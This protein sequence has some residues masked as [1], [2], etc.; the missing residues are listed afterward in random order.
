MPG[1]IKKAL[2]LFK[3]KRR[4]KQNQPYPSTIIKYGAK[5]QYATPQ[6]TSPLLDKD[7]K[8]FTQQVCGKFLF[9][10]QAVNNTL[11]CPIGAI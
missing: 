2:K 11:L 8:K 5:K 3:H 4:T 10:G 6:S 9:W 1:Y 7:G